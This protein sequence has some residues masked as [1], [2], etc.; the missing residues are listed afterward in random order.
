MFE[1]TLQAPA[2]PV[3]G[4]IEQY[5]LDS[6][7][8]KINLSVGAYQNEE[9]VTP[10]MECVKL[11]EKRLVECEITKNYLPIQG[12][13][14]YNQLV[15]ELIFGADHS[16]FQ[17]QRSA[18]AQTHHRCSTFPPSPS[19][20]PSTSSAGYCPACPCTQC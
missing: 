12:M 13:A 14:P 16:V 6:N 5:N 2:D 4:L 3:F 9:G 19:H 20:S 8:D 11:A 15:A 17:N 10:I 7:P 1:N 18:T